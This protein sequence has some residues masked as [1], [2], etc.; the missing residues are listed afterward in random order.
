MKDTENLFRLIKSMSVG[1]KAYFKKYTYMQGGHKDKSNLYMKMFELLDAQEHYDAEKLVKKLTQKNPKFHLPTS[2]NYLSGIIM[3]SLR[4]Y[5]ALDKPET[6]IRQLIEDT[7]IYIEK[8]FR[9]QAIKNLQKAIK[10]SQHHERY[11]LL[12]EAYVLEIRLIISDKHEYENREL[13]YQRR[14]KTIDTIS[15]IIELQWLRRKMFLEIYVHSGG[16]IRTEEDQQHLQAI[17]EHPLLQ[18]EGKGLAPQARLYY[19]SLFSFYY[20]AINKRE[21]SCEYLIESMN[22]FKQHPHFKK[23]F[24][25]LYLSMYYNLLLTLSMLY[26]FEQF[27]GYMAEFRQFATTEEPKASPRLRS[28]LFS[29]Y[30]LEIDKCNRSADYNRGVEV[31]ESIAEKL[32][33]YESLIEERKLNDFYFQIN[34]IYFAKN[35][36]KICLDWLNRLVNADNTKYLNVNKYFVTRLLRIIIHFEL[37]TFS[38]LGHM[39]KS[40][41]RALHQEEKPM[42]FEATL[43]KYLRKIINLRDRPHIKEVLLKLRDEVIEIVKDPKEGL[44]L[45]YF[46]FISWLD[47]KIENRPFAEIRKEKVAAIIENNGTTEENRE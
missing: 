20:R 14:K 45:E 6:E 21:K 13:A 42:R 17:L 2:K 3:R 8:G 5:N 37:N 35:E 4:H 22:F 31:V 10:L 38:I 34:L 36:Y 18:N 24:E 23:V 26:R 29:F 41:D 15:D 16:E 40:T 30:L 27:D 12:L 39:I 7:Q 44:V 1:E 19:Y 43:I 46:D 32:K 25:R 28:T 33:E 11:D 9:K 47:S